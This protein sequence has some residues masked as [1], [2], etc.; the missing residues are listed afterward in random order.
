ML[1]K[2]ELERPDKCIRFVT[3]SCMITDHRL[4]LTLGCSESP[5]SRLKALGQGILGPQVP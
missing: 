5:G 3:I 4:H 1:S 2:G